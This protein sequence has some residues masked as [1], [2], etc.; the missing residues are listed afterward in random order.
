MFSQTTEY[1]LRAMACLALAPDQ[2]VPTTTLA[3]MTRVPSNYLAKVL[4]QLAAAH[5]IVGRRGVGGGYKLA[6]PS[7]QIKLLDVINTMGHLSRITSCPLGLPNHGDNLCPLHKTMDNAAAGVIK[8]LDGVT[9]RH[10]V[11]QPDG[12]RPLCDV[13][14]MQDLT[15]NGSIRVRPGLPS[16][17]V[18]HN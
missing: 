11:D 4:Q 2:L 18:S 14:A 9:L 13:R 3:A 15:V 12:S 10:L 17:A 6:R 7:D 8:M 5:L 16:D 1:A